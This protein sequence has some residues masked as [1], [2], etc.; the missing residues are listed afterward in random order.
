[1]DGFIRKYPILS[2]IG[3]TYFVT[4][5][6]WAALVYRFGSL[7]IDR[8]IEMPEGLFIALAAGS[9]PTTVAIL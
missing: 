9:A 6:V 8:I 2:F 3:L 7:P 4:S 5:A 1:M